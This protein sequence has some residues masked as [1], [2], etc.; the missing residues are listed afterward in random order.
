ML[1]FT[2]LTLKPQTNGREY[3]YCNVISPQRG[4]PAAQHKQSLNELSNFVLI[5]ST[6]I[7]IVVHLL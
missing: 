1:N 7:G 5:P 4:G 2:S 3:E 6:S